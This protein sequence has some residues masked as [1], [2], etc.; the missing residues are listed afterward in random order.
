M[1]V[2]FRPLVHSLAREQ[3]LGVFDVQNASRWFIDPPLCN[4]SDGV[5]NALAEQLAI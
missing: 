1:T 3:M 5:S 2:S 4:N